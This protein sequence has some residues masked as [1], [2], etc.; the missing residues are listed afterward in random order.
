MSYFIL[1]TYKRHYFLFTN[2]INFSLLKLSILEYIR[3]LNLSGILHVH[4]MFRGEKENIYL[5]LVIILTVQ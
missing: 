2:S 3:K 5:L 1:E 4:D